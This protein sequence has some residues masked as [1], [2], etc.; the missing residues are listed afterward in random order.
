[1]FRGVM[2]A[3]AGTFVEAATTR[4]KLLLEDARSSNYCRP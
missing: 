2:I 4:D 3:V 1:M